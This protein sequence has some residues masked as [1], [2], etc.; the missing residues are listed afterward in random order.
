MN[1]PEDVR[2]AAQELGHSLGASHAVKSYLAAQA[3]LES[4]PDA[5][6]LENRFQNLYQ[7]LLAR[8]RADE[9]LPREELNEFYRLRERVQSHP[10]IVERDLALGELKAH[11]ADIALELSVG[12]QVDYPTLAQ[13]G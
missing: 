9:D 8:Q 6:A 11:F 3:H 1:L 7:D 10:L 2:Q 5:W 13:A 12:L 4:D